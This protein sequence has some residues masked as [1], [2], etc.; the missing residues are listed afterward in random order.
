MK[1]RLRRMR[2]EARQDDVASPQINTTPLIDVMLVLLIMLIVTIPIRLGSV[3]LRMPHD[4]PAAPRSS[5]IVDLSIGPGQLLRW[6][7]VPVSSDRSLRGLL[8][9]A[10]A[11]DP[12]AQLDLHPDPRASYDTF[13]RVLVTARREGV[14]RMGIV[15]AAHG[16]R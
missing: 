9:A 16:E 6:N 1:S 15:Q 2:R 7:G 5:R 3:V 11:E 13:A 4:A 14:T 8:H 12:P 10:A